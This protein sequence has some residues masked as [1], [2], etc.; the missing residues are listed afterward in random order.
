MQRRLATP[1]RSGFV[2]PY[3][4][5]GLRKSAQPLSFTLGTMSRQFTVENC[6]FG[7][8]RAQFDAAYRFKGGDWD[9]FAFDGPL[10]A[11]YT[12]L[13]GLV[14][15]VES[16]GFW[17]SDFRFLNDTEEYFNGCRMAK[18]VISGIASR[19]RHKNFSPILHNATKRLSEH[20]SKTYFVCSFSSLLDSLEQWRGYASSHDAVA[21][22]FQNKPRLQLSHFTVMP[23]LAPQKVIYDDSVKRQRLL[24]VIAKYSMEFRKDLAHGHPVDEDDWAQELASGLSLEFMIF[25]NRAFAAEQEIRLVVSESHLKH[26]GDIKHRVCGGR[27]IPYVCSSDLYNESFFEHY[28]CNKLPITEIRVGPTANQAITIDSVKVF[29]ANNGYFNVPITPSA[30]PYRG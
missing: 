27:I 25:K 22:V 4:Q 19:P 29:L 24:R 9:H 13:K 30:V 12:N 1:P 15:I 7:F 3:A 16:G 28:G 17:L 8:L 21:M 10:L 6:Q 18:E 14:G 20:P 11:H 23:I 26:F 5:A 2:Q